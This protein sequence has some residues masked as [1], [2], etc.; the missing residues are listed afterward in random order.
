MPEESNGL[1]YFNVVFPYGAREQTIYTYPSCCVFKR[2][3]ISHVP[4]A[5]SCYETLNHLR[6]DLVP[7]LKSIFSTEE[8][9]WNPLEEVDR[10]VRIPW[11]VKLDRDLE[12]DVIL[13]MRMKTAV[14]SKRISKYFPREEQETPKRTQANG[15]I[16]QYFSSQRPGS[17][18]S[19]RRTGN[20]VV[21]K[22]SLILYLFKSHLILF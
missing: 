8:I 2:Q 7:I 19:V 9:Q 10:G 18:V 21:F 14:Q 22:V 16:T 11:H 20:K 15:K 1:V 5:E 6:Q 3:P 12:H 17:T 4:S 13:K